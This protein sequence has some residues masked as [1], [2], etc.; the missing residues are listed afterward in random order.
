[1]FVKFVQV[2]GF[3]EA[4]RTHISSRNHP[5]ENIPTHDLGGQ[6]EEK[7]SL[8]KTEIRE[9][10]HNSGWRSKPAASFISQTALMIPGS[11]TGSYTELNLGLETTARVPPRRT[12]DN[13]LRVSTLTLARDRAV[14]VLIAT[15]YNTLGISHPGTICPFF[16]VDHS[17]RNAR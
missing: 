15:R 6:F 3:T 8:T 12:R 10:S 7:R 17:R 5:I 13:D 2:S 16:G 14:D 1:M 4:Y 11:L 9:N